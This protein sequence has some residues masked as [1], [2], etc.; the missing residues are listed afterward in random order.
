MTTKYAL[1]SLDRP[2]T[3]TDALN[4]VEVLESG[5]QITNMEIAGEG[6]MNLVIRVTT[7]RRTLIV[8]QSRPWVEKYPQI[9]APEQRIIAE[10]DFY[11]RIG[12]YP[13]LAT[14]MPTMIAA[15]P[16][17][18]MMVMQDL[19]EASDYLC[20]Y[21]QDN[22][23]EI[24]IQD[25][26]QYLVALHGI[27]IVGS[28]PIGCDALKLLNHQH[29]FQIPYQTPSAIDLDSV[30]Q[31]MESLANEIR[32]VH[33][34]HEQAKRFGELF[35]AKGDF[36]LHGDF[37][38]G[39]LLNTGDGLRVIDAEFCFAGPREFDVAVFIAHLVMAGS[40]D[41]IL[42]SICERYDQASNGPDLETELIKNFAGLEIIRR[43][44]GVAQ[45]PLAANL[46]ERRDM[47]EVAKTWVC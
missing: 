24:P 14:M 29:I 27:Q 44:I 7:D 39:S 28:E 3:V 5:E 30:C 16:D 9:A 45:L 15:K 10:I 19:G 11:H 34:L 18:F 46:Q 4:A 36:M 33:R 22:D 2:D 41:T 17:Q 47:L 40:P 1:L 31:G 8:K 32:S 13:S 12:N 23:Q 21:G 20:V 35:L 25:C 6:N 38:P 43:L 42:E 26:L 37:Y